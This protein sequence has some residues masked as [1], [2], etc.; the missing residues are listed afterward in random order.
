M[1]LRLFS[2]L[3]AFP[4]S[5]FAR[6]ALILLVGLLTAQLATLWLQWRE[7]ANVVSVAAG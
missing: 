7:R 3:R 5:L 4:S 2:R 6:M 1:S